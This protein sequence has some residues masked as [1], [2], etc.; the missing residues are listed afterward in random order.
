MGPLGASVL[1]L[2][3]CGGGG[4]APSYT[5][6]GVIS[7]LGSNTGLV[8]ANGTDTLS[9]AAGA[10]TFTMPAR[11]PSGGSY[12]LTVKSTPAGLTCAVSQGAGT[13]SA[14]NITNIAVACSDLTYAVGGTI[15]GLTAA[16]LVLANGSDTLSVPA[17][18]TTFTMPTAV[19]Y[20]SPYAVTVQAQ[21]INQACSVSQGS[22]TMGPQAVTN[23]TVTCS[24]TY[25]LG[26]TISG[27]GGVSGLVLANG[28]D[29]L[30]VAPNTATFTLP[31][32][33]TSGAAYSLTVQAHPAALDC[34]VSNGTGTVSGADVTNID[35]ACGPV[36]W[37]LLYYFNSSDGTR[38]HY[39]VMQ[40]S[41]GN[42]YGVTYNESLSGSTTG[43]V[44][45][46]IPPG[47]VGPEGTGTLLHSFLA[48][49]TDGTYPS[50][51]LI[52]ASDGKLYG[53]TGSGGTAGYG[54]VYSITTGGT[55]S[56]VYSFAGGSDGATPTGHLIKASDGNFY[57]MTSSGGAHSQGTVF[58]IMPG[59][60]E[61]AVYS[62]AGGTADGGAPVGSLIQA[63]DG[64]FYGLTST[65]GTSGGGTVFKLIPGGAESILH[66]FSG[67]SDGLSP[68]D[69]GVIEGSDG[70]FYGMTAAGGTT[71]FG[72]VFKV[73]PDG[74][75]TV[76]HSFAGSAANDGAYP[77]GS[78]IQA[79]DGNLYG[80]TSQGG[81][82]NSGIVFGISASGTFKV[83]LSFD[84]G[85]VG[86]PAGGL[87]QTPDGNLYGVSRFGGIPADQGTVFQLY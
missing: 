75:E 19:A 3:G 40:A 51:A 20:T 4:G 22:G 78:L 8:L 50:G 34:V 62:F 37:S 66:S 61:T 71:N 14:G 17:N 26:G 52:Q 39:E 83:V 49:T 42:F 12:A 29:T 73:T 57:G 80:V 65:G 82:Y 56:V 16:G 43:T 18:A 28:S 24:P 86:N 48:G 13:V 70:N 10:S 67:G 59:G 87:I 53:L 74:T 72:I 35:V 77:S 63:S 30:T 45:K 58:K 2:G 31:T 46:V 36:T 76:V 5:V 15:T 21:P 68:R 55:E 23:I 33:A 38:P 60:T 27:L 47:T 25:T 1:A 9:V 69:G 41:D 64:N 54:T 32:R 44:F 7:G 84:G 85:A 6:G 81:Q 79:N 11:V